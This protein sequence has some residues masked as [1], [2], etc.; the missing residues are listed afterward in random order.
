MKSRNNEQSVQRL[1]ELL[2]SGRYPQEGRLPPERELSVELGISRAA[3]RKALSVLEAENLIWRHVGRGTFVGSRTTGKHEARFMVAEITN[4]AEIM[5]V[6]MVFEPKTAAIAALRATPGNLEK[7][8]NALIKSEAATDPLSFEVWDGALH[9]AIAAST[10][11]SLLV[12]LFEAINSLRED[13][14]WGRL[15]EASFNRERHQFYCRQHRKMVAA[16][17]DRDA[18]EAERMMRMHL[19]A[20]QKNLLGNL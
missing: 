14:L 9:R 8:T 10:G 19:E 12:S 13:K 20:V 11:N 7:I 15:K 6:R 3:L 18:A 2:Q 1:R 5:E 16:I 17:A 4:P